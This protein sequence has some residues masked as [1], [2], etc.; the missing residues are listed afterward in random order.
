MLQQKGELTANA[1]SLLLQTSKLQER[2]ERSE[3][4]TDRVDQSQAPSLHETLERWQ[5]QAQ[6]E[7]R[8]RFQKMETKLKQKAQGL[9]MAGVDIKVDYP[10][11][12][13]C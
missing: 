1:E 9:V 8:V 11:L 10:P 12:C 5:V 6:D 3:E 13:R 7:S 4:R 2:L